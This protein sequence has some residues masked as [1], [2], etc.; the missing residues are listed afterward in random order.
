MDESLQ[1]ITGSIKT[2]RTFLHEFK[3]NTGKYK[4]KFKVN[5]DLRNKKV[6]L[7]WETSKKK[8]R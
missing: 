5:N 4:S 3:E 2:L 7:E 1:I 6:T 8:E